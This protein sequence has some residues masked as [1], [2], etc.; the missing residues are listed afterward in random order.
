[1]ND[2]LQKLKNP[3]IALLVTGVLNAATGLLALASG[4]LRLSGMGYKETLPADE[5]ERLGFIIATVFSYGV[6]ALSLLFA[7]V[8]IFGAVKMMR[9][10]SYN[11]ALGSSIFGDP[12]VDLLLLFHGNPSR[13]LGDSRFAAPGG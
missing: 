4:A 3:A 5:S 1:M 8:I 2:P 12:A 13:N 7:P 11:L 9:G 10:R 6:S